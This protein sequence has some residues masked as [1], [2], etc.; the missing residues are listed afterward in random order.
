MPIQKNLPNTNGPAYLEQTKQIVLQTLSQ[1]EAVPSVPIFTGQAGTTQ[2]PTS[3]QNIH[4]RYNLE[5]DSYHPDSRVTNEMLGKKE[6][7]GEYSSN[8]GKLKTLEEA[9]KGWKIAPK[10]E[11]EEDG[12]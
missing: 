6:A 4:D 11:P 2:I 8:K 9:A 1:L 5:K 10:G 7:S 12:L 3:G